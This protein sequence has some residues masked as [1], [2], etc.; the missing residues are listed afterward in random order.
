[1]ITKLTRAERQERFRN[2]L[3]TIA[4][5][6][7]VTIQPK[8]LFPAARAIHLSSEDHTEPPESL[9]F[10]TSLALVQMFDAWWDEFKVKDGQTGACQIKL[11]QVFKGFGVRVSLKPYES[12]DGVLSIDPP[13]NPN[14]AFAWLPQ[15]PRK[16][17]LD[18]KD[19]I[20]WERNGRIS[21]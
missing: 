9:A 7:D 5:N 10:T 3:N 20:Y 16:I 21:L 6:S 2:Y 18:E 17:E 14:G 13:G 8:K 12:A 19:V 1:M 11:K 15:P 4:K